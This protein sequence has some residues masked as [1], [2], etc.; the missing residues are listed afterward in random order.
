ML[1]KLNLFSFGI[2]KAREFKFSKGLNIILG[3]NRKGK[4]TILEG[5]TYAFWGKTRNSTLNKIINFGSKKAESKVLMEKLKVHRSKTKTTS[6]LEQPAKVELEKELNLTYEE[7]LRL[8][9]ISSQEVNRLLEPAYFRTFLI[10]LFNLT[11]YQQVYQRLRVEY[12]TLQEHKEPKKIDR[13]KYEAQRKQLEEAHSKLGLLHSNSLKDLHEYEKI[14]RKIHEAQGII[15][16]K[17]KRLQQDS[18]LLS[19]SQC[20]T[21]HQPITKEFKIE[22]HKKLLEVK[23]NIISKKT[24]IK[25]KLSQ[26]QEKQSQKNLTLSEWSDKLTKIQVA[27]G[28]IEV[29][30]NQ[31]E[32]Q[33]IDKKRVDELKQLL[34]L[35]NPKNFPTYLLSIYKP[36][37]QQTANNL[38]KTVFTDMEI[39]IRN[40]KPDSNLP[41]F[42]VIIKNKGNEILLKDCSGSETVLVNLCLRLGVLIIY[43]Q[44]QD[45][46]I[47]FFIV[48]EGFEKLDNI[49]SIK[50][51]EIFNK[52][53]KMGYL[54]QVI[55]VTF[56]EEL[57]KLE[58]VNYIEL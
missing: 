24:I 38:L 53:V 15:A 30:L 11:K 27:L 35:F 3:R 28:E 1:A 48:D 44:L 18:K 6:K 43:K 45:T 25:E 42:K 40:E 31:V 19:L 49:N 7:F 13:K 36:A 56:K 14:R 58:G 12:E 46:C 10:K 16:G 57:K 2:H 23:R 8:F 32:P 29:I 41:D 20:Y 34:V 33:Q 52:V 47:D 22:L 4:T 51:L 39:E 54:K 55:L 50:V 21:C 17:I 9:Y 26:V 5:I 37:I